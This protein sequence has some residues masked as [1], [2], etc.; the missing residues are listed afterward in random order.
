MKIWGNAK[1]QHSFAV[2]VVKISRNGI[3]EQATD[4]RI[5]LRL[6]DI[7]RVPRPPGRETFISPFP[8][9]VMGETYRATVVL[10]F[11]RLYTNLK[12]LSIV[13]PGLFA[14]PRLVSLRETKSLR[15]RTIQ[16]HFE[17]CAAVSPSAQRSATFHAEG[18]FRRIAS[19][20]LLALHRKSLVALDALI[21]RI[22]ITRGGW[23]AARKSGWTKSNPSCSSIS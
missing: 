15:D 22:G 21:F 13:A 4:G 12:H 5:A 18:V 20:Q 14:H 11:F 9:G 2:A 17:S 3:K 1:T 16:I 7:G 6:P 19:L 8:C 23:W 10:R